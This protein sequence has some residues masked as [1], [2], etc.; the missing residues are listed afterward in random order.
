VQGKAVLAVLKVYKAFRVPQ[1]PVHRA[2][3]DLQVLEHRVLK[4]C[5]GLVAGEES[6]F[7]SFKT[8][9]QAYL[10]IAQMI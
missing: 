8:Q 9:F 2:H 4:V 6:R 3:K 5:K 1:V 7:N 10:L